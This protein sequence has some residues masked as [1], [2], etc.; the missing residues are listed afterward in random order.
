MTEVGAG[1]GLDSA[2]APCESASRQPQPSYSTWSHKPQPSCLATR[3]A[4]CIPVRA[5]DGRWPQVAQEL[6]Q[7]GQHQAQERAQQH[8]GEN[9]NICCSRRSWLSVV[10]VV[11]STPA[12]VIPR[13][14]Q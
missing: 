2:M 13:I 7:Q 3:T 1:R 8:Q 4:G 12:S 10:Q 6:G 11:Q 5:Q 14:G 9:S